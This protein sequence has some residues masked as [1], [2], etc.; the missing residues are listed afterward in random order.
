VT[1]V[2]EFFRVNARTPAGRVLLAMLVSSSQRILDDPRLEQVVAPAA[3]P[4]LAAVA[5]YCLYGA[6]VLGSVPSAA[7]LM[8]AF[9]H[10]PRWSVPPWSEVRAA[11]TPPAA[12]AVPILITQGGADKVVPAHVTERFVRQLCAAGQRV[13]LRIYPSVEHREAGVLVAPD[14]AAWIA[15]R[16]AGHAPPSSCG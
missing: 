2:E 3:R 5:G 12:L 13:D 1:N 9:A 7:A 8:L 6:Q 11:A 14:V 10:H 16:F 4:A 15:E